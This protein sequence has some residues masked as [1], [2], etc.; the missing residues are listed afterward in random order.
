MFLVWPDAILGSR[1]ALKRRERIPE[2][3]N[4]YPEETFT[5]LEAEIPSF[6]R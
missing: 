3:K 2:G 5:N 6:A 4:K 1:T